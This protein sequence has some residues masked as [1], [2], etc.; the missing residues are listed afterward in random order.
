[1]FD[2]AWEWIKHHPIIII[3]LLGVVAVFFLLSG[4]SSSAGTSVAG[5]TGP[6]DAEVNAG[7]QVTLGQQ[8]LQGQSQQLNAELSATQ[9]NNNTALSI[10]GIQGTVANY[11][12]EQA[13]NVQSLGIT[14]ARDVNMAGI[15]SQQ[16][17]SLANDAT[18]VAISRIAGDVTKSGYAAQTQQLGIV[19]SGNVAITQA[20]DNTF[21][22][23]SANNNQTSVAIA[24]IN[25]KT[26]ETTDYY[27]YKNGANAGNNT[28]GG[29]IKNVLSIF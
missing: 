23:I 6:T 17:V 5:T 7:A 29:I 15:T 12:T 28:I 25:Q 20:N 13:A 1:M 16:V 14:A 22:A 11:Q 9:S 8:A 19:T 24:G 4:S 21:Q 10:A 18:Q 2:N 27:N 3:G 26:Q